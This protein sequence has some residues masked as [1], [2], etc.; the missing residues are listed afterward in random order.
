MNDTVLNVGGSEFNR[1][2]FRM[3]LG[4]GTNCGVC[5]R[6]LPRIVLIRN[7]YE[8]SDQLLQL[9]RFVVLL[10][11]RTSLSDWRDQLGW[12]IIDLVLF[13]W[14]HFIEV[15]MFILAPLKYNRLA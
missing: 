14:F 12:V 11:F 2:M 1:Q 5:I 9:V 10:V 13:P 15:F 8:I 3:I 4:R 6:T 7:I